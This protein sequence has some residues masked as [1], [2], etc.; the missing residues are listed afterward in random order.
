MACKHR[1]RASNKRFLRMTLDKYLELLNWTGRQIRQ[2]KSGSIRAGFTPILERLQMSG[3]TWVARRGWP[4]VGGQT[5]V[6]RRGWPDVGGQT[7]VAR[8]GWIA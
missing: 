1:H 2:D 4:D 7:W 8:R 3:Q 5:W 6:A